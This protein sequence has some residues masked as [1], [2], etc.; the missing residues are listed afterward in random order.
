MCSRPSYRDDGVC[1]EWP[2]QENHHQYKKETVSFVTLPSEGPFLEFLVTVYF[3][4]AFR[5]DDGGPALIIRLHHT[6]PDPW[7][8]YYIQGQ[9]SKNE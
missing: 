5:R 9:G 3:F 1:S 2:T 7:A 8:I 4:A 6:T